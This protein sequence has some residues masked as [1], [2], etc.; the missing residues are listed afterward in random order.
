MGCSADS[1]NITENSINSRINDK[2]KFFEAYESI[3]QLLIPIKNFQQISFNAYLISTSSIPEFIN[4]I[5]TLN[6]LDYI[7]K[8]SQLEE[9]ES[10][11]NILLN[12]YKLEKNI[13][14]LYN[15]ND[16]FDLMKNNK[17]EFIMVDELFCRIMNI[18]DYFEKEKI[19]KIFID[20]TK[21]IYKIKFYSNAEISFEEQKTGF[22]K[23]LNIKIEE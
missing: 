21:F 12:N 8:K 23:F 6:I 1:I 9:I 14:L 16:C 11:L 2:N 13:K 18:E 7:E 20:E 17:N 3:K 10:E 19:V 15:Y 4:Y 22:Y 5:K